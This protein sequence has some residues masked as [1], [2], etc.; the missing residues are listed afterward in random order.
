MILQRHI[1]FDGAGNAAIP[2][3]VDR[4]LDPGAL[5]R[6]REYPQM[7]IAPLARNAACSHRCSSAIKLDVSQRRPPIFCT[8]E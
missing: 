1:G 2:H 4:G 3:A 6:R 5:G 8:C 7:I